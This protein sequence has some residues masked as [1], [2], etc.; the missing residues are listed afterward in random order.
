LNRLQKTQPNAKV[1]VIVGPTAVGK[2]DIALEL[3]EKINGEIISADSM[4]AYKGMEIMSQSPTVQ[5]KKAVPHH[6]VNFLKTSHEYSAAK[7][8]R[9][10]TFKIEDMIKRGKI[11]VVVGGSGLYVK[12]LIHGVFPSKGKS[13]LVRRRL[14]ALARKKGTMFLFKRLER[15]DKEASRRIHPNDLKKVIRA[16]EVYQI[17]KKT[18][19]KMLKETKGVEDKYDILKFGLIR[20]RKGIYERIDKRVDRMFDRGIVREAEKLVRHRMSLTAKQAIGAKELK[21]YFKKEYS[22]E[23]AKDMLKRNTR[24]FAKRQLTWFRA[25]RKIVWLNLDTLGQNRVINLIAEALKE[26]A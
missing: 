11:P 15:I 1:I 4:Q 6:L 17:D 13:R 16:L 12:A 9:F 19:T 22:L 21:G 2:S 10:A 26:A 14:E 25:D 3:A 18:K 20:D 5:E 7:F 23:Q 24:R 8:S